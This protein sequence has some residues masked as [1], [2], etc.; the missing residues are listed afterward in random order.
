MNLNSNIRI[1]IIMTMSI[2]TT[3]VIAILGAYM[4]VVGL[5]GSSI[6]I[7]QD[8]KLRQM[9]RKVAGAKLIDSLATGVV[10]KDIE[11]KV[12]KMV[13]LHANEIETQTGLEPSLSEEEAKEYLRFVLEEIKKKERS[14]VSSIIE[15]Y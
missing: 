15:I 10:E 2:G 3:T 8:S 7:A 9:I 11:D 14:S 5:Y 6:I 13:K 12:A 1:H 4:T